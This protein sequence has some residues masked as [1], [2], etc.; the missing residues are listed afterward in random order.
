LIKGGKIRGT[1]GGITNI[2]FNIP[3]YVSK[4]LT[5]QLSFPNLY[6]KDYE[7][8]KINDVLKNFSERKIIRPLLKN[9]LSMR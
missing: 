1:W 8:L 3:L 9:F 2:D 5:N 6:F 7:F 4:I